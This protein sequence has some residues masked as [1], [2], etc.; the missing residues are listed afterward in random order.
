MSTRAA[1]AASSGAAK[2]EVV[3]LLF[4]KELSGKGP[5]AHRL[6]DHSIYSY[7]ELKRAYLSRLQ[8]LH[9]DK[10]HGIWESLSQNEKEERKHEF[11]QLQDAWDR[12]EVF[13]KTMKQVEKGDKSDAS[14][15]LFGVGCSF[16]DNEM[17]REMRAEITDQACRGWFSAGA[18]EVGDRSD[19][20]GRKQGK[21]SVISLVDDD[22]FT[23]VKDEDEQRDSNHRKEGPR[24]SLVPPTFRRSGT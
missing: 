2:R 12:Y 9:P 5:A 17:E 8:H 13:A 4:G 14:F 16:S 1:A 18:L 22:M 20:D 11:V 23:H 10:S 19:K 3:R 15:T 21:P 6:L 24:P 7:T